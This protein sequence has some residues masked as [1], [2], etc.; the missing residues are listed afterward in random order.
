MK[1][2]IQPNSSGISPPGFSPTGND[3]PNNNA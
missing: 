2:L 1:Y 3:K